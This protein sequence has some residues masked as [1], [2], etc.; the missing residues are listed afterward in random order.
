MNNTTIGIPQPSD[1]R[2]CE[3]IKQDICRM[4]CISNTPRQDLATLIGVCKTLY[5]QHS[6][7][8]ENNINQIVL[9]V[10]QM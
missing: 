9:E 7:V 3:T 1:L 4:A 2:S 10:K 5:D 8:E 6:Q